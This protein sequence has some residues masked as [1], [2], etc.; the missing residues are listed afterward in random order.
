MAWLIQ[1]IYV[2]VFSILNA[3]SYEINLL[4]RCSSPLNW[5]GILRYCSVWCYISH[6]WFYMV[7]SYTR[8]HIETIYDQMFLHLTQFSELAS[9]YKAYY[10]R[11]RW[12]HWWNAPFVI[13]VDQAILYCLFKSQL[14]TSIRINTIKY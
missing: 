5:L 14:L 2:S 4:S 3:L 11:H 6:N 1:V 12:D 13:L 10:I 9:D 8:F 7:E